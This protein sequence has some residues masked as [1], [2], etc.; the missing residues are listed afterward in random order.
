MASAETFA[1][2]NHDI[3]AVELDEARAR[4]A[5]GLARVDAL[6]KGRREATEV[7]EIRA[8]P[9]SNS[10]VNT[11]TEWVSASSARTTPTISPTSEPSSSGHELVPAATQ[12][13]DSQGDTL[14]AL[15]GAQSNDSLVKMMD[16]I[17]AT[18]AQVSS[19]ATADPADPDGP[20]D[21]EALAAVEVS[22][23]ASVENERKE[24][25]LLLEKC[26]EVAKKNANAC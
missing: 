14:D 7:D 21:S 23:R 18:A 4:S 26:L 5:R 10:S 3:L 24:M 16:S 8:T 17:N 9:S 20:E 2:W 25:S 13:P 12:V 15:A 22:V 1:S 11:P 6:L 19:P